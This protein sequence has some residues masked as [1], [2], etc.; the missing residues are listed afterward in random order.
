MLLC[1]WG[2]VF[3]DVTDA[4]LSLGW[5]IEMLQGRVWAQFVLY[6]FPLGLI[7]I[8]YHADLSEMLFPPNCLN[9]C[10]LALTQDKLSVLDSSI[11]YELL[12]FLEILLLSV[13]DF[14][15]V[16]N[17]LVDCC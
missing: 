15:E 1:Y 7:S 3:C 13:S 11:E 16:S 5:Q 6:D 17:Q 10:D 9:A 14:G 2:A 12:G 8:C 4:N